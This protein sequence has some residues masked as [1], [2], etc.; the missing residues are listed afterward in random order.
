MARTFLLS[1][2]VVN[3]IAIA[4][5]FVAVQGLRGQGPLDT[6][7]ADSMLTYSRGQAVLPVYEGWHP[8]EDG[9][10]DLWFGYLNQNYQEEPDVPV[11]PDNNISAPYGPDG[12]QPTHFLPRHNRWVFW[13]RVPKD[14]GDKEVVWTLTSHGH[15]YRTYA[16]LKPGYIRD[17]NGLS[18][19]YFGDAPFGGNKPPSI[20]L[21]GDDHRVVKANQSI[22]LH[23]TVTD[24]GVPAVRVRGAAASSG[25]SAPPPPPRPSAPS[26][27][28]PGPVS[29]QN[30]GAPTESG[31]FLI[32]K[33][34]R[35]GCFVYRGPTKPVTIDPPQMKMWEDH[36]GGSAFAAGFVLPPVPKDGK[37][38]INVNFSEPGTYVI[39]CLAHDGLRQTPQDMTFTVNP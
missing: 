12:S 4:L 38:L 26:V 21:E 24:D 19:E 34:L 33:G 10:I 32:A 13:V 2:K 25:G 9:T 15:T 39:R 1:V 14:F 31:S 16:T 5:F 35:M 7:E 3:T 11:G 8:N 36:R 6:G 30:C 28:G 29:P 17:D 20:A 37:Y 27:C 23:L 22:P 18:R